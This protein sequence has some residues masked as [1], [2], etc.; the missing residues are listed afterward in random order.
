MGNNQFKQFVINDLS[1]ALLALSTLIVS[2]IINLDKLVEYTQESIEI[3][4][5]YKDAEVI[6]SDVYDAI[7]DK[8]L[9]RQRELLE[10][11][12]DEAHDILSYRTLR[13]LLLKRKYLTRQLDQDITELINE[14]HTIRNWTFHNVQSRLVADKE[15][16][17][18]RIPPELADITKVELQLNPIYVVKHKG[19]T[20]K[21]M[22]SFVYHNLTRSAQFSVI[23][24]EMK[25]DYQDMYDQLDNSK[26]VANP[27][28]KK[29]VEDSKSITP[30]KIIEVTLI[31]DINDKD[32]DIANISMAIQKGKYDG[33][34][35]S[36]D[37][38]T[39]RAGSDCHRHGQMKK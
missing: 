28:M 20:K 16:M 30:V 17:E 8:V 31:S 9:F 34:Q 27:G 22:E 36:F 2:S 32:T 13:K 38:H 11:M 18:K 5:Q 23:L 19:Y 35:E 14:L 37:K 39:G 6:P 10:Y 25:R 24:E 4:N 12:A 1:D 29:L 21:M 15:A 7:H 3:G 33:T 26:I